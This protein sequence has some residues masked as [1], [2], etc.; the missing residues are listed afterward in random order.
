VCN[1]SPVTASLDIEKII[2]ET[3][4]ETLK[5]ILPQIA[6][7]Q[8]DVEFDHNRTDPGFR[9][10]FRLGQ[11][12]IEHLIQSQEMML[13]R[14]SSVET[15]YSALLQQ[16]KEHQDEIQRLRDRLLDARKE[17]KRRKEMIE[18]NQNE[19]MGGAQNKDEY[20]QVRKPNHVR[21]N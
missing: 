10:V 1:V 21:T 13:E 9:K 20:D 11:L 17:L 6:F 15:K 8:P 3:D 5:E 14:S 18:S 12:I 7:C 4:E 16:N 2:E 19:L